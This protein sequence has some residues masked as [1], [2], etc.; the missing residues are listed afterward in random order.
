MKRAQGI[1]RM[2][3]CGNIMLIDYQMVTWY[4]VQKCAHRTPVIY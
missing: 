2:F 3:S 1:V 4:M